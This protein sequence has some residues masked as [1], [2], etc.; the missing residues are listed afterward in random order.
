MIARDAF[1]PDPV[2]WRQ[3]LKKATRASAFRPYLV[4]FYSYILKGGFLDGIAGFDY[5]LA[6][7]SY[8]RDVLSLL[9]NAQ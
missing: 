7:A 5:A 2:I 6:K 1:P 3:D 9:R 8:A 4:F